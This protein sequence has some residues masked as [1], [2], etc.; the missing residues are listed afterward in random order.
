MSIKFKVIISVILF[1]AIGGVVNIFVAN[2]FYKNTINQM[3]QQSID[4]SKQTFNGLLN[5]SIL[6][7]QELDLAI[8]NDPKVLELYTKGNKEE[9]YAYLE[10]LYKNLSADFGIGQFNFIDS[11]PGSKMFLR[12]QQK[13]NSGDKIN[14]NTYKD[15]VKSKGFGSGL[16]L[17]S[18]GFSVRVVHPLKNN[19]SSAGFIE[20]STAIDNF[21]SEMKSQTGDDYGLLI[22][23]KYLDPNTWATSQAFKKTRNNWNDM[24]DSLLIGNTTN[25]DGIIK[26]D[27][28]LETL[29]ESGCVLEQV[30]KDGQI[31][32][33]GLFP[34]TDA[35]TQKA[36]CNF[37]TS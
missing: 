17:G 26:Y 28:N 25:D 30:N 21:I 35:S 18:T 5:D 11:P 33:R 9:L 19:S 23:K 36:R 4:I 37:C 7:N 13:G 24:K 29:P 2:N 10:P 16:E 15:A 31:Y 27:G 34:I 20:M 3:Q 22:E 14:R 12:M 8:I 1:L 6:S 32:V